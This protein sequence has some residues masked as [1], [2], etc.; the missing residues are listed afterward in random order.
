L[1]TVLAA[2]SRA[3]W[4]WLAVPLY[5]L[6]LLSKESTLLLPVGLLVLIPLLRGREAATARTARAPGGIGDPLPWVLAAISALYL[7]YFAFGDV[8]ATRSLPV[9]APYA[10]DW[11]SSPPLNALSY[12]GWT[13]NFWVPTVQGFSDAVD[14]RVFAWGAAAVILWLVGAFM[15]P[16]RRRG[17]I[18]GGLLYLLLLA[19]VLPLRN[20]T[21]HYYLYA[22]LVGAA[23]CVAALAD[24]LVGR[25]TRAAAWTVALVLAAVL[26]VNGGL[27][28]HKIETYP[29][30]FPEMRADATVDRARIARNVVEGLREADIPSGARVWFWSPAVGDRALDPRAVYWE[31]NL[32]SA[33][34]DGLA[35][36]VLVPQV[37]EVRFVRDFEPARPTDRY[38]VYARD[39]RLRVLASAELDSLLRVH[40]LGR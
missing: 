30:V 14:R 29:F 32:R 19:P 9:S 17:W 15:P 33:L 8:F 18:S 34:M 12:L 24:G 16:L 27:L 25:L 37:A 39:G 23:W 40:P 6:S 7:A 35:L 31:N 38:A 10:L 36:R 26:V 2:A 4:R 5:A 11:V 28:V 3:S 1:L 22:P 13:V 20:H 21:Y